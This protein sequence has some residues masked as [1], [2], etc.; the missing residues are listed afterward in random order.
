[1]DGGWVDARSRTLVRA[2]FIVGG[3]VVL[4]LV[5]WQLVGV[6]LLFFGAV[7]VAT[8]LRSVAEL[9]ERLAPISSRWS[10]ALAGI[11]IIAVVA[12]FLTLLGAQLSGQ[13]TALL[14]QLPKQIAQ[15]GMRLGIGDLEQTLAEQA[16][17]FAGRGDVVQS[18]AGY[19]SGALGALTNLV[20][21][22]VGGAYLAAR[23]H[24]YV[25]GCLSVFPVAIR[26]N[27]ANAAANSGRALKLW[28]IG[29]LIAM[30]L[31]GVFIGIGLQ[32][33]GV[34]SALALALWAG[35]A[36]FVPIVGP[37]AGAVPALL[38][39][40]PLGGTAVLWVLA[41]F[42]VVQQVESNV[43]TPLVQRRTVDLPPVLTL[44][45]LLALGVLFGPVGVVLGTPLTV[46]LYV[47]VKQLYLRDTLQEPTE[48]PGEPEPRRG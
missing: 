38:I 28:L 35:L 8:V 14:E 47:A 21:V 43:I 19:T 2:T 12:A 42:L 45:A 26:D 1:V 18:I 9:I 48:V 6:M 41:L 13:L 3:I 17:S 29:Q 11:A 40:L 46:V 39:A 5:A 23:P 15:L 33:V 30:V 25:D 31:V 10:L 20:I 44:F 32:L 22:L 24:Y 27:V 37:I 16:K 34:P 7:V 36:E 4:A